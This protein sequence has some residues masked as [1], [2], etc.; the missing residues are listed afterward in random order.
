MPDK[1]ELPVDDMQAKNSKNAQ[2]EECVMKLNEMKNSTSE[3]NG[4]E[5]PKTV[6]GVDN[7][8]VFSNKQKPSR[9]LKK[10]GKRSTVRVLRTLTV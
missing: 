6:Q 5:A 9:T 4:L 3:R 10:S 8:Q 1:R 7:Q 2:E